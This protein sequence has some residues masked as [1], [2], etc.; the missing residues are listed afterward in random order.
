[1]KCPSLFH[2]YRAYYG[3]VS[4]GKVHFAKAIAKAAIQLEIIF[5][6]QD[7][8]GYL[9]YSNEEYANPLTKG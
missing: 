7:R 8:N 3:G 5:Q 2:F 4:Q 9:R 6:A 1:M